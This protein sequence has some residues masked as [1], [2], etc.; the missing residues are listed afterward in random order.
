MTNINQ[1]K[2]YFIYFLLKD[3][4]HSQILFDRTSYFLRKLI[5][6]LAFFIFF[7]SLPFLSFFKR[8]Y[9][10]KMTNIN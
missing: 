10:F 9:I 6:L 1:S 2:L 3:I 4:N 7:Y 8:F 5:F